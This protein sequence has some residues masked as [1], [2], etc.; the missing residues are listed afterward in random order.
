VKFEITLPSGPCQWDQLTAGAADDE[1]LTRLLKGQEP[2]LRR[3][4]HLNYTQLFVPERI[5]HALG[6]A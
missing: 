6:L 3:W 4:I 1:I 2:T 5:L